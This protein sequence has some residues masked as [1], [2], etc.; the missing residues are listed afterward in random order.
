[1]AHHQGSGALLPAT[2]KSIETMNHDTVRLKLDCPAIGQ[3]YAGQF[4]KLHID[5][6]KVGYYSLASAPG[7]DDELH[8]H[9]RH[10]GA[11]N[12]SRWIHEQLE[13]GAAIQVSPPQG[14][15]CYHPVALDRPLLMIGTGAG[16]APLYGMAR[17]ALINGHHGPVHLYHGARQHADLY[18]GEQLRALARLYRNFSYFPCVSREPARHS[19]HGGR[20]LDLAVRDTPLTER[21]CVY[22]CGNPQMVADARV[23]IAQRGV[24][25]D[26]IWS[27]LFGSNNIPV[28]SAIAA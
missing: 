2:V 23:I 5:Q 16:L 4:L 11:G 25:T 9:V 12:T 3:Y 28:T 26:A 20:A 24:P 10:C 22:L 27:D 13:V 18:L 19:Y 21:W 14:T 1:M 6:E 7:I 8:L 17:T 15:C